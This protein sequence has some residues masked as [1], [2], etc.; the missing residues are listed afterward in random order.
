MQPYAYSFTIT[1]QPDGRIAAAPP[2]PQSRPLQPSQPGPD[3]QNMPCTI[4]A[5]DRQ[6]QVLLSMAL[7]RVVLFGGLLSDEE[8][9]AMIAAAQ[10]KGLTRS[11]VISDAGGEELHDARTSEGM[12]FQRGENEL[13]KRVEARIARLLRW[14]VDNGEGLQILHYRPGAEYKPHYDYFLPASASTPEILTHGGQRVGTLVLYL[15]DVEAGGATVFPDVQLSIMPRRGHAVFFGYDRPDP[16]T[17]TLHG[18]APVVTGEKWIA[19]KWLREG[20]YV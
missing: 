14:P 19:T 5:G 13:V 16:A 4:D 7:P 20:A 15:D 6:V 2:Q 18:G 3:L 11:N 10:A 17:R 8:C 9:A 1:P 12:Y